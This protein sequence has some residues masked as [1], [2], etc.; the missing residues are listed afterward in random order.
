MATRTGFSQRFLVAAARGKEGFAGKDKG[1]VM[2]GAAKI[3]AFVVGGGHLCFTDI[4]AESQVNMAEAAGKVLAVIP[5]VK[6][7][8]LHPGGSRG[9]RH[10]H[11]AIEIRA[12][13]FFADAPLGIGDGNDATEKKGCMEEVIHELTHRQTPFGQWFKVDL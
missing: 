5:V 11:V 6:A 8:T 9:R 2:A 1:T 4:H 3:A 13:P 7:D 10:H 12:D